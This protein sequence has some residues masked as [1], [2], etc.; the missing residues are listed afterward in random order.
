MGSQQTR[1]SPMLVR[2]IIIDADDRGEPL[3]TLKSDLYKFTCDT[4]SYN[5]V[6]ILHSQ[7]KTARHSSQFTPTVGY[8]RTATLTILDRL[9]FGF[10]AYVAADWNKPPVKSTT[11]HRALREPQDHRGRYS[12]MVLTTTNRAAPLCAAAN[13][14]FNGLRTVSKC[15]R[16]A[17]ANAADFE[18]FQPVLSVI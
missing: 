3:K 17:G 11:L 2:E 18:G 15:I 13:D 8:L 5:I 1:D 4:F 6:Q 14:F 16:R 12:F 10:R 9:K 7:E